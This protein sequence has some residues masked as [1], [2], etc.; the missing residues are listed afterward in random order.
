MKDHRDA[1]HTDPRQVAATDWPADGSANEKLLFLLNYAVLAPSILNAEPWRFT[2]G[3][4]SVTLSEDRTRRLKAVD[5]QGREVMISCGAALLNLR[6]AARSF[7]AAPEVELLDQAESSAIATV[8]LGEAAA[9]ASEED[10]RLRDAMPER[11]TVR[12]RFEDRPVPREILNRLEEAAAA[13]GARLAWTDD[14]ERRREAASVVAEAERMHLNDKRYR[15]ELRDWLRDRRREHHDS[16]REV[17]ARM[18][19]PAGRTVSHP[20]R[21]EE[22]TM[23]AASLMRYFASADTAAARQQAL[24][25]ASPVV[26]LL[27]AAGDTPADWLSAGQALQRVL[28][29]ATAEGISASYLNP[30]IEQPRLRPRL[31][32]IFGVTGN[33]Q[34]LLRLGYHAPVSAT[35]R[36]PLHEVVR[37]EAPAD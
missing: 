1:L 29:T 15:D 19:L 20:A 10:R 14:A 9:Q 31:A 18:G 24:V 5:P 36:R 13:E 35:P 8:R 26:A 16:L 37:L 30:P 3:E 22:V 11:R 2:L 4:G 28:L 6:T 27:V 12:G 23:D 34:V 17:F 25:E 7:G 33:P 32:E 21:P